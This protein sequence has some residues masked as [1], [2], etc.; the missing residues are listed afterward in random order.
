MAYQPTNWIANETVVSAAAL[1]NIEQ[2]IVDNEQAAEAAAEAAQQASDNGVNVNAPQALSDAQKAQA[3]ANIGAASAGDVD[4]LKSAMNLNV[5]FNTDT[6][7]EPGAFNVYGNNSGQD[8]TYKEYRS[9]YID[10]HNAYSVTIGINF[11]E[12]HPIAGYCCAYDASKTAIPING[13]I[14]RIQLFGTG[15]DL[16]TGSGT[17]VLPTNT[18][19]IRFFVRTF[20]AEYTLSIDGAIKPEKCIGDLQNMRNEIDAEIAATNNNVSSLNNYIDYI[21]PDF[22]L[23]DYNDLTP[24]YLNGQGGIYNPYAASQEKTSQVIDINPEHT[25]KFVC[26]VPSAT[27]ASWLAVGFW[28]ANDTWL[29]RPS[30]TVTTVD[31]V[32]HAELVFVPKDYSQYANAAYMRVSWRTYGAYMAVVND[33]T[34][35]GKTLLNVINAEQTGQSKTYKVDGGRIDVSKSGFDV[36]Q[37]GFAPLEESGKYTQGMAVSN[38]VIFQGYGNGSID[39][40]DLASGTLINSFNASGGHCGSL[41][42]ANVYPDGNTDFPYL[43]VASYNENKTFVYN[44]TRTEC[45]LEKTYI[46]PE[47]V[48]GYC[49]ETCI[50]KVTGYLWCVGHLANSYTSGE[51]LIVSAWDLSQSTGDNNIL[52]PTE[53]LHYNLPWAPYLQAVQVLNG[54]LFVVFGTDGQAAGMLTHILV[55]DLGRNVPKADITDFPSAILS[56]EPEGIDFVFNNT[57]W[58]Y[59]AILATR[60]LAHYY[61]LSF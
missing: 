6:D 56:A 10:L 16:T 2:G 39:L 4:G 53:I 3:R 52:T 51:G 59:D 48:A 23:I 13:A 37:L 20:D 21:Y 38:G 47:N 60:R 25:Y 24:G 33:I 8:G 27:G 14:C 30:A 26:D 36:A 44:V 1:N 58:K 61:K 54:Q 42:F 50:D 12:A 43:Y 15:Q 28:D 41:S 32:S 31:D 18:V 57:S 45:T 40:I 17:F 35:D 34:F 11:D 55:I 29:G 19:Y 22:E 9:K 49:Q 46:I 7:L 5:A